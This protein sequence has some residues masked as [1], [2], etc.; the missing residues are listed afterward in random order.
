MLLTCMWRWETD[1][2]LSAQCLLVG[3][4]EV[5][6]KHILQLSAIIRAEMERDRHNMKELTEKHINRQQTAYGKGVT[7]LI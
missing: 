2:A 5:V 1:I 7:A 6:T 4:S 3:K